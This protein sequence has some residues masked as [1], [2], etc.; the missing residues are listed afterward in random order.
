M[1]LFVDLYHLYGYL[2]TC[3]NLFNMYPSID[4]TWLPFRTRVVIAPNIYRTCMCRLK[5]SLD[6]YIDKG[7]ALVNYY[8]A[9]EILQPCDDSAIHGLWPWVWFKGPLIHTLFEHGS[10]FQNVAS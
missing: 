3:V 10:R 4:Y 8:W 2:G 6:G 1:A 5:A 9:K 7:F